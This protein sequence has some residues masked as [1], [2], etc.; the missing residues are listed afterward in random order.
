MRK[1]RLFQKVSRIT[2]AVLVAVVLLACSTV[3]NAAE[4]KQDD[5]WRFS[6][7]PYLWLPS[8]STTMKLTLPSGLESRS[9]DI[10]SSLEFALP[11]DIEVRKGR[12]SIFP[13]SCT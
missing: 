5:R 1:A 2:I 6:I 10:D 4:E 3:V 9:A 13:T 11:I 12:W 8:A 7:T